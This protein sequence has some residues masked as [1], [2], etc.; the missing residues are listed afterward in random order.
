ML[1]TTSA[2]SAIRPS[3]RFSAPVLVDVAELDV[4]ELDVE[5]D[6]DALDGELDAE[7]IDGAGRAGSSMRAP[8]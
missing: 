5:L 8:A 4:A 2:V 3:S 6:D 7:L 1:P